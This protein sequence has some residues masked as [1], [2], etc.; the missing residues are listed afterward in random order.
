[1]CTTLSLPLAKPTRA[2]CSSLASS[3]DSSQTPKHW[4]W[5]FSPG[6]LGLN[7]AQTVLIGA[8]YTTINWTISLDCGESYHGSNRSPLFAMASIVVTAFHADGLCRSVPRAYVRKL[9][10]LVLKNSPCQVE[11]VVWAQFCI[12]CTDRCDIF[13]LI[14]NE[15][16]HVL[17][18]QWKLPWKQQ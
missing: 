7:F 5:R 2:E 14:T 6:S 10:V 11:L 8:T 9:D 16:N 13:P 12:D 15:S 4:R 1:V 17:G 18:L 3:S